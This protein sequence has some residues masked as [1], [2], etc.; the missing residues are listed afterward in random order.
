MRMLRIILMIGVII[1]TTGNL[2]GCGKSE[3]QLREI[4]ATALEEKYEEEFVCFDVWGN[5]GYSYFGVCAPKKNH[6][7]RFETLF[8]EGGK[9]SYDG[10]YAANVAEQIEENVQ[11]DLENIFNDFYLHSYMTVPLYSME[12]DDIY[13]QNVRNGSF[14]LDEY[15]KLVSEKY[16]DPNYTTSISFVICVN[17]SAADKISFEEEYDKLFDTFTKIDELGINAA[18]YLK[19]VPKKV[20]S[21]CIKYLETYADAGGG[22]DNITRDYPV[23]TSNTMSFVNFRNTGFTKESYINQRKEVN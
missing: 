9:I 4:L 23:K 6:S 15:I 13:A 8:F 11:K 21:E 16:V 14:E 19:F 12:D 1:I 5:G 17:T 22:F 2:T 10:Y 20:Y 7:I 3:K 18:I